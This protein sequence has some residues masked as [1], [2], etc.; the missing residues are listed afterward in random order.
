ME[1]GRGPLGPP[2]P[3]SEKRYREFTT[4][5]PKAQEGI[6]ST[7][8][9]SKAPMTNQCQSPNARTTVVKALLWSLPKNRNRTTKT[10]V[11]KVPGNQVPRSLGALNV[12]VLRFLISALLCP[13]VFICGSILRALCA[14]VFSLPLGVLGGWL[15]HPHLSPLP[16]RERK[17]LNGVRPGIGQALGGKP[18]LRMLFSSPTE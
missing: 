13:S 5:A 6:R 10:Q 11:T 3:S 2:L 7:S 15:F 18:C 16:L 9:K 17:S 1:S 8:S 12:F 14:F 4:K